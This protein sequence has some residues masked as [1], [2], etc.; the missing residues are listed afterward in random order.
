MTDEK[1]CPFAGLKCAIE[2]LN[3]V[4][5]FKIKEH[6]NVLPRWAFLI[7]ALGVLSLF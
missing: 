3:V 1:K 6:P 2:W 4:D 5:D 7:I